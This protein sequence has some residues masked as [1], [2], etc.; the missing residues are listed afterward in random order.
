MHVEATLSTH[1]GEPAISFA[2]DAIEAV[3]QPFQFALV[4][5]FSRTRPAMA[6]I[7]KFFLSLDLKGSYSFDLLDGRHVLIRLHNEADFMR[8]WTRNVWY[9]HG[10][11]MRVFKWT[12]SFH[13][14]KESSLTPV[15]FGL[16]KL[17]VHLFDKQC[18]FQIV[19]CLGR[20][21]FIDT[22]IAA[23]SRPS[24]ARV[25]VEIDLLKELPSR[26]W[27][28]LGDVHG[29]WQP[30]NPETVPKYYSHCFRQGHSQSECHVKNPELHPVRGEKKVP[31]E[32]K[33]LPSRDGGNNPAGS[34]DLVGQPAMEDTGGATLDDGCEGEE[35][36]QGLDSMGTAVE[37]VENAIVAAADT[38][39]IDLATRVVCEEENVGAAGA[40]LSDGP[41]ALGEEEDEEVQTGVSTG[42]ITSA[43]CLSPRGLG[44]QHSR[45]VE[46]RDVTENLHL[47]Q[48]STLDPRFQKVKGRG[49][50]ATIPS[51]RELR[52]PFV[53]QLVGESDQH[54]SIRW[55]HPQFPT[56]IL[57]SFVHAQCL[58]SDRQRL[59]EGLLR[60]RPGQ[61]PWYVV[62][63][64]NL[65][66]SASE[67]KGGRHFRPGEGVEL[68]RFM[69]DG[70]LFDAGFSGHSFTWCNNRFGR[71]CIWKRLDRLLINEECLNFSLSIS[72][73][74]L[75][76]APSDH[77]PLLL[78]F[79]PKPTPRCRS[80]RFLN[81]WP[82]KVGFL[83]VVRTAWQIEVSGSPFCVVWGKLKNVSRALHLWNKQVFG[84]IFENIKQGEA[85]VA[86]AELRVQSNL[87]IEAHLE[88]QRAQASLHRLLAVE[89]Q[90]WS[91]K[92][93][94]KWLQHG[95]RN[96]RYFHSVVKQHR[97]RATI[98]RI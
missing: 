93:R 12:T 50:R 28:Q 53:S 54:L 58:M 45:G 9:I 55:A 27:I 21:L 38:I 15:W 40:V 78:S 17:P 70:G 33:G 88:V 76:R 62:G 16:P 85:V 67:K 65:I 44:G 6:D 97:F 37:L 36:R 10:S 3:A 34:E 39:I 14:D 69:S 61:G 79:I 90:F 31:D 57:V 43:G 48:V 91:Q 68:S 5:K 75:V 51:D 32:G 13:I 80:F 84:D 98:H 82:S 1:C 49:I 83:D 7:R 29:F 60:D 8:I 63:D 72:V 74:H 77:A 24:V 92:A 11:V 4:G 89:E 56:P 46:S 26:I 95:D 64:F 86:A 35:V 73:S 25:C 66:L 42:S 30:L 59:W 94:V 22:A 41:A 2:R 71:A 96:S 20:P 52:V 81:V 87:S 23:L 19:S 18:L 47:D